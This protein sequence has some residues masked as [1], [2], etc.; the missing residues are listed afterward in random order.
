MQYSRILTYRSTQRVEQHR[1]K[2]NTT[3]LTT[4]YLNGCLIWYKT[5]MNV[6][7]NLDSACG[8]GRG[9][10]SPLRS[11]FELPSIDDEIEYL[12]RIAAGLIHEIRG[13]QALVSDSFYWL[14]LS[15]TSTS[16]S[17]S[18][19]L[20]IVWVQLNA[21]SIPSQHHTSNNLL[22]SCFRLSLPGRQGLLCI[23][24][25]HVPCVSRTVMIMSELVGSL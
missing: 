19:S 6:E 14:M 24:W 7:R 8:S 2:L 25:V 9:N 20:S 17:V 1:L 16:Q 10:V 23:T 21:V 13:M 3:L 18:Q 12:M 4:E 22:L 11:S 15:T 5:I